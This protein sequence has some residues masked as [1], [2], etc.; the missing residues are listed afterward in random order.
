M[1]PAGN[2]RTLRVVLSQI[3]AMVAFEGAVGAQTQAAEFVRVE[4][5]FRRRKRV[6]SPI[7]ASTSP[8]W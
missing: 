5:V 7:V 1:S 6:M 3:A 8:S 2:G 4:E